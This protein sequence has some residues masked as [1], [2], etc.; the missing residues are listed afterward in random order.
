M[1]AQWS[2]PTT[3]EVAHRRAGGRR[4]HNLRRQFAAARRRVEVV[5]LLGEY[6]LG[7]GVRARVARELKVHPATI[8]RDLALVLRPREALG[9][10]G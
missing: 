8:T 7:P 3:A 1:T 2:A 9:E 10:K 4:A 6:G 5:R